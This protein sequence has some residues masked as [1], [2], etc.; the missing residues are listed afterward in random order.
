MTN[1]SSVSANALLVIALCLHCVGVL[2]NLQL[3]LQIAISIEM[4]AIL[5]FL[6]WYLGKAVLCPVGLMF[7]E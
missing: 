1:C 3:A 5:L 6:V 4:A 2:H 7:C